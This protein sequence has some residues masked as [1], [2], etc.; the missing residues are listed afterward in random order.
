[1]TLEIGSLRQIGVVYS[2]YRDPKNAPFQG[3]HA[4]D[5]ST[6]EAFEDYK[7]TLLDIEQCSHLIVLYWQGRANRN[8]L[9]VRTPWGPEVHCVFATRSSNRP[10]P[11]G[12]C[13]VEPLDLGTR[14]ENL[15]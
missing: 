10:N 3:K 8:V 4:N 13:V 15:L 5:E 6:L 7:A 9:Q 14:Y 1:M 12:P 11:I 2:P